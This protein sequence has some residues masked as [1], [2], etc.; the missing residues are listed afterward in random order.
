MSYKIIMTVQ[1][2]KIIHD[3]GGVPYTGDYTVK[4]S[5]EEDIT[6]ATENKVCTRDITVE[7]F[8]LQ[9]KIV[10]PSGSEQ[11]ITA[12]QGY[13][14]LES[15]TVEPIPE[16]NLQTK[17]VGPDVTTR[18]Y[19]PDSGYVGFSEFTVEGA[20][21]QA[22]TVT[23]TTERQNITADSGY[24]ALA[25]VTV[26]PIPGEYIIPSGTANITDNGTY[27]VSNYAEAVVEVVSPG[28]RLQQK[29]A[30]PTAQQQQITPDQGYDGLSEVTV[31]AVQLESKTATPTIQQQIIEPDSPNVG[32]SSV[33]VEPAL[34]QAKTVTPAQTQQIIE[35]DGGYY[36]LSSV[37]VE[38]TAVTL[39]YLTFESPSDF[40]LEVED[41][42]K[43]WD[44]TLY[45]S[46]DTV[47]W[48]VWN[49]AYFLNSANGKLYLRG[50]NNTVI[51]NAAQTTYRWVITGSNVLCIG[52][53]ETLLDAQ[54]VANG[55]HPVMGALAFKHLF[56][57]NAA[58]TKAPELPATTLTNDCYQS[59]FESCINLVTAPALPATTL[60]NNCYTSM[61]K[62]CILIQTAPA[63]PATTL[64]NNCYQTMFS[65]CTGL[66]AAPALPATTL[67]AGCYMSMFFG[68]SSLTTVPALPATTLANSCYMTMFKN[69]TSLQNAPALPATTLADSC[70]EGMFNGC[71][72]LITIPALPATVLP[73]YCYSSMFRSCRLI[74]LSQTQTGT[75][76]NEYRLP[77]SGT[78]TA[79]GTSSLDGMFY[80]T[81]GDTTAIEINTPFYTSNNVI[82]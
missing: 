82:V 61:F 77:T 57:A 14:G 17:M 81:G 9:Q 32:L 65:G 22:K 50:E 30:T 70:Y 69:C 44:G 48:S 24:D 36:G 59:M 64:A 2:A 27:D 19:S 12:D 8:N 63:L 67:A 78:I 71:S 73:D 23:P 5:P 58:L 79:T 62:G 21:L 46:T 7:K 34:L 37:T 40:T 33:T 60:A 49:A 75:Y 26:E 28:V 47:N 55:G 13:D 31:N 80:G 38:P 20:S 29:T 53:I 42:T 18:T 43:H 54:T 72:S 39:P 76:Q 16:L 11:E 41:H 25:R 74:E 68:C 52:N 51:T 1:S 56:Y 6:L 66:T 10:A 15:V 4:S 3:G 35:P 45:Y